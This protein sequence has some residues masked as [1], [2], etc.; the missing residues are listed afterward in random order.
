MLKLQ[1]SRCGRGSGSSLGSGS[2]VVLHS[3]IASLCARAGRC[4][5]RVSVTAAGGTGMTSGHRHKGVSRGNKAQGV[6]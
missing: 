1:L 5:S 3:S 6:K 4:V 2:G